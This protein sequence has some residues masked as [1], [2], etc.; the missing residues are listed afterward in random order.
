ML[1]HPSTL[2]WLETRGLEEQ[3]PVGAQPPLLRP[4]LTVFLAGCFSFS[5]ELFV[6]PGD[7]AW[8]SPHPC[9][10][11][12][13]HGLFVAGIISSLLPQFAAP[14]GLLARKSGRKGA[15]ADREVSRDGVLNL[16][17]ST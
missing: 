4:S 17:A 9:N 13:F 5:H 14:T 15:I 11:R 8:D 12:M 3:P 6:H 2:T 1:E 7:G 16:S 10:K